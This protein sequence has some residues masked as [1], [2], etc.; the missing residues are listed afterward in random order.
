MRRPI[1]GSAAEVASVAA[2]EDD[3]IHGDIAGADVAYESVLAN[4][5]LNL[6]EA[7]T[8]QLTRL[9]D[10]LGSQDL[11][12][13]RAALLLALGHEATLPEWLGVA[14]GAE[15]RFLSNLRAARGGVSLN[16]DIGNRRDGVL[17]SRVLGVRIEAQFEGGSPAKET[18]ESLLAAIES[19][20][21]TTAGRGLFGF[22]S[23]IFIRVRP[24]HSTE[25]PWR[26]VDGAHGDPIEVAV[27]PF[28][29]SQL[30]MA[31]QGL[32]HEALVDAVARIIARGFHIDTPDQTL[33]QLIGEEGALARASNFTGSFVTAGDLYQDLESGLDGLLIGDELAYQ[34]MGSGPTWDEVVWKEPPDRRAVDEDQTGG[35]PDLG[36][37]RHDEMRVESV[38]D[39]PVWDRARWKGLAFFSDPHGPPTVAL[40]FT[41]LSAASTIWR[42]WQETFGEED[43]AAR[44]RL[45]IVTDVDPAD[46]FTYRVVVGPAPETAFDSGAKI[47]FSIA[48]VHEMNP[49]SDA[50][51]RAF[52]TEYERHMGCHLAVAVMPPRGMDFSQSKILGTVFLSRIRFVAAKDASQHDPEVVASRDLG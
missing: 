49:T 51:L 19:F 45:S 7:A 2:R 20:L 37:L 50:N 24:G 32:V 48:R 15:R 28:D 23:R 8:A 39:V 18:A 10:F 36:S 5:L 12:I 44:L 42:Q 9:P 30:T 27:A 29:P 21:A 14:S 1:H 26:V 46:R 25:F 41:D 31:R 3:A 43:A 35:A 16:P 22:T 34:L 52:R 6:D 11:P 13:A 40:M 38:I 33:P 17:Q 47:V 4:A